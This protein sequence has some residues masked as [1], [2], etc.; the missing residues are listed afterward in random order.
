MEAVFI[1]SGTIFMKK[2]RYLTN[3]SPMMKRKQETN[4][5]NSKAGL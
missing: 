2:V 5:E 4:S 3:S 1:T